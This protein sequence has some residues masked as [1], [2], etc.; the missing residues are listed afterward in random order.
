LLTTTQRP[1]G[2]YARRF[3]YLR[4]YE[5]GGW[6]A[7]RDMD[8]FIELSDALARAVANPGTPESEAAFV[9]YRLAREP[10]R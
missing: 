10:K 8:R 7:L 5:D 1:L 6:I 2:A 3:L 9:A 4:R